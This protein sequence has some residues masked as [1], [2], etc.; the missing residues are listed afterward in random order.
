MNKLLLYFWLLIAIPLGTDTV[1]AQA[2]KDSVTLS[3]KEIKIDRNSPITSPKELPDLKNKYNTGE[4][5]YEV[6][7]KEKSL[8]ERFKEWLADVFQKLFGLSQQGTSNLNDIILKVLA[9]IIVVLAIYKIVKIILNKEGQWVFGK[10]TTEKV[11]REED[12]EKNLIHVDFDKLISDTL[13]ENNHRLAIR[14][15]YL[16]VLKSLSEKN[17]IDWHVDKT[18]TDYVYEIQPPGLKSDFQYLSYVYNYIWY[19][20]FEMDEDHF[21]QAQKTFK[22]TIQSLR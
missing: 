6:V 11:I 9:V 1:F 10:S 5:K 19:G 4:F 15:Y 12:I 21:L 17:I 7:L 20:E 16:W 14:Y 3:K 22:N 18:N 2:E 13:K 8:W